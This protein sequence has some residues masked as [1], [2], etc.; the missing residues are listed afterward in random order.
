MPRWAPI[1]YRDFHDVP[2]I[3][4]VTGNDQTYLFDCPFDEKADEYPPEY[5]VY[6]MPPLSEQELAGSWVD[7]EKRALRRLGCVPVRSVMFDATR[8]RQMDLEA[9]RHLEYDLGG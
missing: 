1:R 2:R 8:R 6:L 5:T 4:L 7:F 3:F 9:F